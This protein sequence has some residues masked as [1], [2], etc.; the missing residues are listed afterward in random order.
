MLLYFKGAVVLFMQQPF[1][2]RADCA[3]Y[4]PDLSGSRLK[5]HGDFTPF[6]T[7]RDETLNIGDK[8]AGIN[9]KQGIADRLEDRALADSVRA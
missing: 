9:A 5:N 2:R 1:G 7:N 4:L 6:R 3:R 8:V